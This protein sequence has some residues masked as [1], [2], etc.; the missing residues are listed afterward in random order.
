MVGDI[1]ENCVPINKE[2]GWKQYGDCY[3]GELSLYTNDY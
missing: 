1:I 2:Y 3:H